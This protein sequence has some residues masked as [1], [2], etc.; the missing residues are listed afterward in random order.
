MTR[1]LPPPFGVVFFLTVHDPEEDVKGNVSTYLTAQLNET[2]ILIGC[3]VCPRTTQEVESAA[4]SW[5]FWITLC[6]AVTHPR[7]S[8]RLQYRAWRSVGSCQVCL[9]HPIP[10]CA[11]SDDP[12]QIHS[13]LSRPRGHVWKCA[14]TLSFGDK[15]ED[16]SWSFVICTLRGKF[17][18]YIRHDTGK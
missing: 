2:L 17:L 8:S 9:L 16:C 13:V 6:A 3:Y 4:T 5:I 11:Q 12:P 18:L 1:K 10:Q 15:G 7:T 14:F